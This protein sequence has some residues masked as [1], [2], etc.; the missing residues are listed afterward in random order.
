MIG[1]TMLVKSKLEKKIHSE[2]EFYDAAHWLL[3]NTDTM[4]FLIKYH[5]LTQLRNK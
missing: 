2:I 4:G 1:L 3:S 5:K